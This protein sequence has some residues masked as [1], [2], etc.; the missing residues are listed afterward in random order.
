M[1]NHSIDFVVLIPCYNN[2]DGLLDSLRSINYMKGK[3]ETFIVD[4]GSDVPISEEILR[5]QFPGMIIHVFR[6]H[7]NKGI[8]NALNTALE[9]FRPRNDIK[10]IARLD[11]GDT[12]S[13]SR[14]YK[15][16]GFLNT[17]TDISLLASWARFQSSE[18]N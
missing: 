5:R 3:Y 2:Y 18:N 17:H 7:P 6:I 9:Q 4:D 15:Q 11:A 1:S 14:F 13:E 10:Y 12:C 16:V 8:L